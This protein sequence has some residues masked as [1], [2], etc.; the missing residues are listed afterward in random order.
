M[1]HAINSNIS[2]DLKNVNR[3]IDG[4]RNLEENICDCMINSVPA[5]SMAPLLIM[6]CGNK[7]STSCRS[8]CVQNRNFNC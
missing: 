6:V 1:F 7:V 2:F 8:I 4:Q 3:A 5:D